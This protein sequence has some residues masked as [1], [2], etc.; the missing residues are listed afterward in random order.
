APGT[1][2]LDGMDHHP[3][4]RMLM[5]HILVVD[6]ED[7]V[8][9]TF[10]DWLAQSP[11][12]LT[13]HAAA[14]AEAALLAANTHPIDLAILDWNLG[15]GSDGLR[16][17]EDLV[18][19]RPD[20]VAI[21]ITGYASQATPLD[22]LRKGVRD[23]LDKNHELNRETF[24]GAVHRQLGF[25]GPA[26]RQRQVNESLARFR[27]TVEAILPIVRSAAVFHEPVPLPQALRTLF[28]LLNQGIEAPTSAFVVCQTKPNEPERWN[29]WDTDGQ[30][31]ALGVAVPFAQSLVAMAASLQAAA[32]MNEFGTANLA[33]VTLF[34]HETGR[35][36]LL[37]VPL[38][39]GTGV[40]GLLELFDKPHFTEADRG[41]A[42]AAAEVGAELL[43]QLLA[44]GQTQKLLTDAI[45]SALQ[46]TAEVTQQMHS[47]PD[48]PPEVLQSLRNTL[49][50]DTHALLPPDTTLELIRSLRRLAE[51]HGPPAVHHALRGLESLE[52]MLDEYHG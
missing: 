43:K 33:G 50:H 20:V 41:L 3:T 45:E 32:I 21:L 26:R 38:N 48:L 39:L 8:R 16:L 4:R 2:F 14:D 1:R 5:F 9:R 42:V 12:A 30:P 47:G 19:F 15:S 6:D 7:S 36:T 44:E 29:A 46:A 28:R 13:V 25:I 51:R 23:Y 18:E 40:H 37:A 49:G 17:L 34:P 11:E 31:I 24:L 10:L 35:K 22:A 27:T 52:R